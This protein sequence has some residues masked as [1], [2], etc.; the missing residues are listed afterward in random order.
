MRYCISKTEAL[1]CYEKC[2]FVRKL[3]KLN[4]FSARQH[5]QTLES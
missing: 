3:K 4:N 5:L 1:S 2:R